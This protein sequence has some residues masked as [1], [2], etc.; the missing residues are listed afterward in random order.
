VRSDFDL[1]STA[2]PEETCVQGD[3]DPQRAVDEGRRY[4]RLLRRAIGREPDGSELRIH[5]NPHDLG[6]YY[7]VQYLFDDERE[8][9]IAYMRRIEN[10]GP[11]TWNDG[12]PVV[13]SQDIPSECHCGMISSGC[14]GWNEV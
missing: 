12:E 7:T 1:L 3:D 9:H 10:D 6:T 14:P 11:L 4:I 2:P 13:K 8:D 5:S